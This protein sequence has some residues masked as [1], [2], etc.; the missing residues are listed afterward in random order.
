MVTPFRGFYDGS[1][2]NLTT[3]V[4]SEAMEFGTGN[5]TLPLLFSSTNA[6]N[7]M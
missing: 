4:N 5:F 3:Y 2:H 1:G 6:V 7:L